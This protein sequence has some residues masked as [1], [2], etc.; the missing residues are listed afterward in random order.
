MKSVMS[1][2]ALR[3]QFAQAKWRGQ[4]VDAVLD[5]IAEQEPYC[6]QA[7]FSAGEE[8]DLDSLSAEPLGTRSSV[9]E[10]VEQLVDGQVAGER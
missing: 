10:E 4:Q 8:D 7:Q 3:Q 2:L 6:E 5:S 9:V 1:S